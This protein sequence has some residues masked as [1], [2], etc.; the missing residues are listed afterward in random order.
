MA[1]VFFTL[2]VAQSI[3]EGNHPK[4]T[5]RGIHEHFANLPNRGHLDNIIRLREEQ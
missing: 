1:D 4:E 2:D 3:V 5:C